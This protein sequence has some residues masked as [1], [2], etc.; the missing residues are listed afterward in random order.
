[1]KLRFRQA[2][3]QLVEGAARRLELRFRQGQI[4]L[5]RGIVEPGQ[6]AIPSSTSTSK[7]LPVT[8]DETVA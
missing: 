5:L 7:T 1:M 6:T 3:L 2:H 8:L 4:G